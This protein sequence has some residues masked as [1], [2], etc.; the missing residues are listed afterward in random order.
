MPDILR[1]V[2][3][4][5]LPR[6]PEEPAPQPTPEA[7]TVETP[8]APQSV[9]PTPEAA[10]REARPQPAVR[11][12]PAPAADVATDTTQA[13]EPA[14]PERERLLEG[15]EP[16]E[17]RAVVERERANAAAA[18][19]AERAR[20]PGYLTF[21]TDDLP[22]DERP[23][24]APAP[25]GEIFETNTPRRGSSFTPGSQRTAFGR[26]V[27]EWCNALTNGGF[28]FLG[29]AV[30]ADRDDGPTWLL[31]DLRPEYLK[32]MPRCNYVE[33]E[34]APGEPP[35]DRSTIKCELVP[36]DEVYPADVG[37]ANP[38]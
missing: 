21:S 25:G 2:W 35:L 4:T 18:V 16:A 6:A 31:G 34:P 32:R 1:A 20:E 28:G 26:R 9:S 8:P 22:G 13:L 3:V 36:K 37:D 30:C 11:P 7:E 10:P 23:Y 38:R 27:A 12:G 33:R 24:R 5:S 14:T 29:I 17:R 15:L 19:V